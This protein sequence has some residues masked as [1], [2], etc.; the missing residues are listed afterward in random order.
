MNDARYAARML[1]KSPG[2][3]FIAA[4]LLAAGIG[5]TTVIFSAVDAVML[6]PLP[7]KHPE[8]LVRM[9]QRTPQL[10][11]RSYFSYLFYEDLRDHSSTVAIPFGESEWS[12]AMNQPL[13]AEEI[14]AT[15]VTPEFFEALGVSALYGRTL[16]RDDAGEAPGAP[17]AVVSYGFWQRRFNGEASA[18]GREITLREHKFTI[19]GVMPREFNGISADTSPDV[20]VPAR[21][22]PLLVENGGPVPRLEERTFS[23]AARLRPGVAPAQAHAECLAMW[24]ASTED[25]F[26]RFPEN[27][28]VENELRRGMELEPLA[29]GVSTL[30]DKFSTALE[31]LIGCA[32]LLLMMTCA[33]VGGLLLARGAARREEVA[34]R[35]AMGATRARI[36]RQM[37]AESAI[38]AALGSAG[39]L[40]IAFVAT[41]LVARIIPPMRDLG[42]E[43][44]AL[45]IHFGVDARVLVFL[46]SISALAVLL[47]GV[48]PAASAAR[49]NLD[50]VLRSVRSSPGWRSRQA[51]IVFQIALCTVLLAGAGLLTRTLA[52]LRDVPPGFDAAHV[53]TFT[54]NPSLDRQ[55]HAEIESLRVALVERARQIPGVESVAV[56]SRPLMRGSGIKMTI[57]PA[58]ERASAQD[59]LNTSLNQ[60]S[61]DY[62]STL[63]VRMVAGRDFTAQDA[64]LT[65]APFRTIVN[66]AFVR[67]FFPHSEPVGQRFGQGSSEPAKANYEIIGVVSD[68]KYRSLR[69]P[70]SPIAYTIWKPSEGPFQLVVR[71]AA[72]PESVIEPVRRALV[73]IDP[74]LPFTEIVSMPKEIDAS[75]APERTTARLATLFAAAAATLAGIGI[76]GLLAY[77]VAQRRREIGIRMAIGARPGNIAEMIGGQALGMAGAGVVLGLGAAFLAAPWIGSLLYGIAASDPASYAIAAFFVI[78]ISTSAAAFPAIRATRVEP[79]AAL[80]EEN[81]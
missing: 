4:G 22:A 74:A 53:V 14:R 72:N 11:A 31:L 7:V 38:L 35:L 63:G 5:A 43:R 19:V 30:R 81:A 42:T 47:C 76:Y 21:T 50:S 9:V 25:F 65:Q 55:T 24:R 40:L 61:P 29:R 66:E 18:V 44:M 79:A 56:A 15:L 71:T 45:S 48:A 69:E 1:A 51:L 33:N 49:M 16:T 62:F 32:A 70:M 57:A 39:G 73:A 58:G 28:P 46:I 75:T 3:T 37:L 59:F 17:P 12:V 23:L 41:P 77:T 2:F 52:Q 8:E 78:L 6:R 64:A 26:K 10:G 80:R 60:I 20:R 36:A 34:V 67:R 13:P 68:A 27:G 54:A